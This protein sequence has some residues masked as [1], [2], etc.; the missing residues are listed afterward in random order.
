MLHCRN[1][2]IPEILVVARCKVTMMA[3]AE[4]R[5][6]GFGVVVHEMLNW[7]LVKQLLV[8]S[9]KL[10]RYEVMP[11]RKRDPITTA[12]GKDAELTR[13]ISLNL[14]MRINSTE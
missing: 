1:A 7:P 5:L 11:V 8:I 3:F 14:G 12:M 10:E 13:E 6:S 4:N 9:T 2:V